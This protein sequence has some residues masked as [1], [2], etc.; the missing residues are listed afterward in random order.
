MAHC[1]HPHAPHDHPIVAR[2][3][4]DSAGDV[5]STVAARSSSGTCHIW[6]V[7]L[8]EMEGRAAIY[9]RS[10]CH[11]W[12]VGLPEME[13]R[14]SRD[15]RSGSRDPN[16]LSA[17]RPD[18][19]AAAVEAS[20]W[21]RRWRLCHACL[22]SFSWLVRRRCHFKSMGAFLPSMEAPLSIYLDA[23]P[24]PATKTHRA[25]RQAVIELRPLTRCSVHPRLV[26]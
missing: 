3:S 22:R 9:G 17:L 16:D 14:V 2:S 10:G 13:G 6:K 24:P 15:G 26:D 21:P 23:P 12:K 8:P 4:P 11:I 25:R 19:M 20:A 7:R 5:A 18:P 1:R